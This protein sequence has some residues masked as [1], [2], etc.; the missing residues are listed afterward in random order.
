MSKSPKKRR[1]VEG[2]RSEPHPADVNPLS[3]VS[4]EVRM[5]RFL[6][7][8]LEL[9]DVFELSHAELYEICARGQTLFEAGKLEEARVI[10]EGLTALS[11]YDANF[12]VGLACVY[13]H[14]KRAEDALR[15]LDRAIASNNRFVAAFALRAELL[16]ELGHLDRAAPDLQR[17]LELDPEAKSGHAQRAVGIALAISS[18]AREV[19]EKG[20]P[21]GPPPVPAPAWATEPAAILARPKTAPATKTATDAPKTT[22]KAAIEA[23]K[24]TATKT[25]IEA[26]K[27]AP[28]A[29]TTATPGGA[30][31]GPRAAPRT[32]PSSGRDR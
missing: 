17:V 8:D 13:Q 2:P 31:R 12:H 11:P 1:G 7:G 6:S 27:S 29:S 21:K 16:V 3:G 28:S 18:M 24:T 20:P 25:A 14:E 9:A 22:A 10:F 26:P 15:E 19:A 23:P 5:L 30:R 32:K 4:P